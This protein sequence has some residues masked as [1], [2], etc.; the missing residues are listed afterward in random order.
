MGA[1]K[2]RNRGDFTAEQ[3]RKREEWKNMSKEER[4]KMKAE[5]KARKAE[6]KASKDIQ[7]K[8]E[9]IEK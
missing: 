7:P 8:I 6:K 3:K 2:S 4:Q 1:K 9:K 5:R